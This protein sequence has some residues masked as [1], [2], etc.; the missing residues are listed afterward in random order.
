MAKT[1]T[2]TTLTNVITIITINSSIPNT[3]T[4]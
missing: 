3:S 2:I 4:H 1:T